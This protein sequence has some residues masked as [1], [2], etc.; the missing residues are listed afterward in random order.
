METSLAL[1]AT[2][3]Q[4]KTAICSDITNKLVT[5]EL[6]YIMTSIKLLNENGLGY[7]VGATKL[8]YVQ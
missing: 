3:K 5:R 1:K 6:N 8:N 2:N 4:N 7:P